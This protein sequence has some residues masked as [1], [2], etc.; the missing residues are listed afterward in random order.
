[1]MQLGPSGHVDTF[2]RDN[3]PP[4]DLWPEIDTSAFPYPPML[5]AAV[6]LTDAMVARGFGDHTALIGNGRQR[7]Y[8]EL[9]DWTNRIAHAARTLTEELETVVEDELSFAGDVPAD[10][11]GSLIRNGI[12][13]GVGRTIAVIGALSRLD[14][15]AAQMLSQALRAEGAEARALPHRSAFPRALDGFKPETLILISLE[16]SPAPAI[17]LQIRQ[18]RR[19]LPGVRIGVALWPATDTAP[20]APQKGTADFVA[21]GMEATLTAAFAPQQDKQA[22]AG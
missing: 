9:S 17:D 4:A 12:L 13:D 22:K 21:T 15:A 11:D 7:T 20:P 1:M 2:A 16:S 6:E 14:D 10:A 18:I 8:K 3:L 19:R 5:N